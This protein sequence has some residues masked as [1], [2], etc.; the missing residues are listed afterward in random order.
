M[1]SS[2]PPPDA[3]A[4]GFASV[5]TSGGSKTI[6]GPLPVFG[7][8]IMG[9]VDPWASWTFWGLWC[10]DTLI[11]KVSLQCRHGKGNGSHTVVGIRCEAEAPCPGSRSHAAPGL[12]E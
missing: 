1:C 4:I 6:G 12:G 2:I 8:A 3:C 5:R 10:P 11:S 9:G 7:S